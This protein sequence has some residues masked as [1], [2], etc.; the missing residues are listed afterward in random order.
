MDQMW[1][2]G[3]TKTTKKNRK[4]SETSTKTA[5]WRVG[6]TLGTTSMEGEYLCFQ[7]L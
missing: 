4:T 5:S 1:G 2:D 3:K 6:N 7:V